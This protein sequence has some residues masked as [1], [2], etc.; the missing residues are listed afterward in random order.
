[1]STDG[2]PALYITPE[3]A[4]K[5]RSELDHLWRVKRPE[6][7]QRVS[8]AAALGDRSD[9]AEYQ[10]GKQQLREIDSRIRYLS[11]RLDSL[12][13]VDRLPADQRRIYFG[14]WVT[15]TDEEG[16]TAQYRIVG[17]DEIDP[18][19]GWI[20]IDSPVARALLGKGCGDTVALAQGGD[21]S[22]EFEVTA[23]RYRAEPAD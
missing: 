9:N 2:R 5:L 15:L 3:G 19:Q 6:V 8:E 7:T 1:M 23:V 16:A 18:G 22:R 13:V 12:T 17:T 20:S 10:Y 21:S 14:A 11:K 4:R